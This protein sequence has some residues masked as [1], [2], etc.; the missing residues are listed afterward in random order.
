MIDL[1]DCGVKR[2]LLLGLVFV[3]LILTGAIVLE[4][5]EA[6]QMYYD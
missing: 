5:L 3:P 1:L 6:Y 2:F 4:V